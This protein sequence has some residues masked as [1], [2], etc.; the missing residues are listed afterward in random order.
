MQFAL[1]N[2]SERSGNKHNNMHACINIQTYTSVCICVYSHTYI[3]KYVYKMV[4]LSIW[5]GGVGKPSEP[6]QQNKIKAAS[7][8]VANQ[9]L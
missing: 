9:Q 4:S 1:R 6:S 7:D 3:C 8:R 2:G 5:R